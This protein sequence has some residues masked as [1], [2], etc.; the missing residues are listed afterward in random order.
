MG[1]A[2]TAH[3]RLG[4]AGSPIRH[5]IPQRNV[6]ARQ[7][8]GESQHLASRVGFRPVLYGQLRDTHDNRMDQIPAAL[9][10]IA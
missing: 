8:R 4:H 1:R 9:K 7:G 3:S 10:A 6:P 5:R 2:S